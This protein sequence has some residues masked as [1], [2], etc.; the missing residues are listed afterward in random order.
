MSAE[1]NGQL[2][3]RYVQEVWDKGDLDALERFLSPGFKR[4]VSP[5][6]PPLDRS[7]QI[8]R[9]RGFRS[10]FPDITLTVE[11][12]VAG[13][14]RVAFRS[15]IRGTHRGLFAGRAATEKQITVGLVDIVRIEGGL[16]VE[17]WGGPD[18]SDLFR[19][20]ESG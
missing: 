6:L 3:T 17:Q 12:V 10:A 15:T 20:L 8:K 11:D 18:M 9:L 5:T 4:H 16:F 2:L 1:A 7:G 14:D 19:Q 13:D